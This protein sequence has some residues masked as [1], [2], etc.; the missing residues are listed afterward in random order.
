MIKTIKSKEEYI[1]CFKF[2]NIY[3]QYIFE[4]DL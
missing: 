4:K 3:A 2:D 1:N